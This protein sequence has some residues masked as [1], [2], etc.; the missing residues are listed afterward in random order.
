MR[1]DPPGYDAA[2]R[3]PGSVRE[4]VGLFLR[5]GLLW[6]FGVTLWRGLRRPND[7]AEAHWLI[8]YDFGPIKRGLPATL[9]KPLVIVA[10][11]RAEAAITIVSTTLTAALCAVLLFMCW[12]ILRRSAFS[13][14]AVVTVAAFLTSPLIV[15]SGHLNGYFDA[16]IIL[17]SIL[18]VALTL[19][20][21]LWPAAFALTVGLFIHEMIFV[22]GF[23]TVVWAALLRPT[24]GSLESLSRRLAPFALP[25][26]AFVL[27][28]LYQSYAID[29][30]QLERTL[31]AHLK[32]FPFIQYDQEVIVPRSFAKS[33]VAHFRSQ[34]PRVWGRLFDP[35]LMAAM[36]PT[37][38][39][40]LLFIRGVLRAGGCSARIDSRGPA[41]ALS[42][43]RPASH[44]LGHG[45]HLGLPDP[46]RPAGRLDGV[47]DR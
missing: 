12:T 46:C 8:S 2:T 18:A 44:R 15:M 39:T 24:K 27:L 10:P 1:D 5:L 35:K 40:S 33:F 43:P 32:T 20:E 34:S 42:A 41:T 13:A 36:L 17:L 11:Q 30:G 22:I 38:L 37:V 28:F 14:N 7:W 9:L 47:P 16:Q 29:A 21:R 31:I 19:R 26:L 6:A 45:P 4:V 3:P 25:L 23:P